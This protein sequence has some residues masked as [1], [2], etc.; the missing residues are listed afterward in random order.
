MGTPDS[1]TYYIMEGDFVQSLFPE[2][3]RKT[4]ISGVDI[5]LTGAAGGKMDKR[6]K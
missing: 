6:K 4:V 1:Y 5:P 3:A 2:A